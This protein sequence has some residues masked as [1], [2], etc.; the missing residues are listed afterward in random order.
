MAD[1]TKRGPGRP[2]KNPAANLA[3]EEVTTLGV[4]DFDKGV[5]DDYLEV[6][7]APATN[8]DE[9]VPTQGQLAKAIQAIADSQPVKRVPYAKFK[10]RSPFNPRGIRRR[11]LTRRCYQNGFPMDVRKLHDEE[12]SLLNQLKPGRYIDNLVTVVEA[13][14]GENVDLHL[15]YKNKTIDQRMANAAQWRNLREMLKRC[16][17]GGE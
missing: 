8:T 10:T 1:P 5:P 3:T 12:I 9:D 16:V 13:Q 2:R 11:K 15:V 17:F 6:E 4:D 7:A 14:N